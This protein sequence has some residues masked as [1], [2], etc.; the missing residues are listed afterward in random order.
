[1]ELRIDISGY[2]NEVVITALPRRFVH[3]IYMHCLGK[4]NTP[5][6]ANNCFKGVLY[7]DEELAGK[8]ARSLD[9]EWNGWWEANR[10]YHRAA[11]SF[12]ESLKV[13][14]CIDGVPEME[15]YTSKLHTVDNPVRM[16]SLLPEVHKDEVLV[17]M[18]SVDKGTMSY[19]LDGMKD[20][21]SPARLDVRIDTFADFGFEEPLI[22][23]MTYGSREL[24]AIDGP[25]KGRRMIEPLLF[26]QTGKELD[27]GDFP[28]VELPEL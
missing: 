22:T 27:M 2:K 14:A 3:K 9:Y 20:E 21:F 28:P 19:R 8:F 17:L 26:S 11:Y 7:F 5:Y 25:S 1:M 10:F 12:E 15:L 16:Q 24:E 18:G 6:F 23:G 4:N 13:T